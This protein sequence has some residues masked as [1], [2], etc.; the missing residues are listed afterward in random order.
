M[1]KE[2]IEREITANGFVTA[3]VFDGLPRQHLMLFQRDDR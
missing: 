3:E 2:Q 1:T